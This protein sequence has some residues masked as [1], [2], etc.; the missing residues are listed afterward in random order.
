MF[1]W[2]RGYKKLDG[3]RRVRCFLFR[4]CR[5]N[6]YP[7]EFSDIVAGEITSSS[8]LSGMV[9]DA[10]YTKLREVSVTYTLPAQWAGMVNA[11]AMSISLAG[12]NLYTW[13]D[14]EGLE[15]EASFQGGDRGFGQW[16]QNVTPQ[17]RSF[18][19]SIQMTF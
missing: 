17:L 13:T 6:F 15:P 11:S 5:E 2:K 10:S 3:N 14:Y 4:L 18:V 1:D 7:S 16:E 19:G 9:K 8:N 12:R